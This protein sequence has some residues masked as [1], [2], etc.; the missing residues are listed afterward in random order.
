MRVT[1]SLGAAASYTLRDHIT[2]EPLKPDVL[3]YWFSSI[4]FKDNLEDERG[5]GGAGTSQK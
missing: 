3:D 4:F 1:C 5:R 2:Q